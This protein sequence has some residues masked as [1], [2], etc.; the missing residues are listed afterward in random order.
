NYV[1]ITRIIKELGLDTS[2]FSG[3]GWRRGRTFPSRQP[4]SVKLVNGE[5]TSTHHLKIR[6]L[7]EGYKDYKCESCELTEWFETKIPL[8]LDHIDGNNK[9]NE[10][11]NLRLL[12]PNCHALTPTYRRKKSSLG[13]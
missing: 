10:I 3:K 5:Y 9:N 2:H 7:K 6:L 1:H 4:V 8:E 12:C 13:L 11:S